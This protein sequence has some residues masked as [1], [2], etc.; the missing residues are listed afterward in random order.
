MVAFP[1][2][3]RA[4]RSPNAD[5][6]T[7]PRDSMKGSV[8]GLLVDTSHALQRADIE[9]VLGSKIARMLRL[10]LAVSLFLLLG[11]LQGGELVFR[12][13]EAFLGDLSLQ[14]LETLLEDFQVVPE[15]NA[16]NSAR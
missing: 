1:G 14:C 4:T 12:Q 3:C 5:I 9:S 10:N 6:K 13:Y 8:E 7:S 2:K 16:S 11:T 15:P